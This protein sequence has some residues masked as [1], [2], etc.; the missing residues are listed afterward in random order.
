MARLIY[1]VNDDAGETNA[2]GNAVDLTATTYTFGSLTSNKRA[3]GF[4]FTGVAVPNAATIRR[5]VLK[6]A[7]TAASTSTSSTALIASEAADNAAAF[8]TTGSNI[9]SRSRNTAEPASHLRT[10][11]LPN[12]TYDIDV[13]SSIQAVINRGGWVSGNALAL[14][15]HT[16]GGSTVA[17]Y[18]TLEGATAPQ[19]SIT[20]GDSATSEVGAA[21]TE[22][23]NAAYT[24]IGNIAALDAAYAHGNNTDGLSFTAKNFGFSLSSTHAV[25][26]IQIKIVSS[27]SSESADN[28]WGVELS[29]DGGTSWTTSK[30]TFEIGSSDSTQYISAGPVGFSHTFTY[31][32]MSDANFRVRLTPTQSTSTTDTDTDYVSVQVFYHSTGNPA[33]STLTDTFNA[34]SIDTGK[35]DAVTNTSDATVVQSGG[36]LLMTMS[37]VNGTAFLA[38][39]GLYTIVGSSSVVQLVTYTQSAGSNMYFSLY[40]AAFDAVHF[41]IQNTTLAAKYD[42]AGG[43]QT[44]ASTTY[45]SSTHKWLRMRELSGTFYWDYSTDGVT[46]TNFASVSTTGFTLDLANAYQYINYNSNVGGAYAEFDNFNLPMSLGVKT[47]QGKA[48]IQLTTTKTQTGTARLTLSTQRPQTG[49]AN[50]RYLAEKMID[51]FDDNSLDPIYA[52]VGSGGVA[53]TNQELQITTLLGGQYRGVYTTSFFNFTGSSAYIQVVD[54]GNQALTS[55]ELYPIIAQIDT[56]NYVTWYLS[57]GTLRVYKKLSGTST[58]VGT[59]LTYNAAVHK[60]FRIRESAG[61]IYFDWGTT[62]SGWTNYT[63]LTNP[64]AVTGLAIAI[65]AGTWQ[66]EGSTTVVKYDNLNVASTVQLQTGKARLSKTGTQTQTG[67]SKV[68]FTPARTITGKGRLIF[69]TTRNQVGI[70]SVLNAVVVIQNGVA[71]IRDT[72]SRPQTGKG[73]IRKIMSAAQTGIASVIKSFSQTQT[74]KTNVVNQLQRNQT[75]KGNIAPKPIFPGKKFEYKVSKPDETYVSTLQGVVSDFDYVQAINDSGSQFEMILAKPPDNFGEGE[76]IVFNYDVQVYVY[77][78]DVPTGLKIFDGYISNYT[79][80]FTPDGEHVKVTVLGYGSTMDEYPLMDGTATEVPYL[81]QDPGTILKDIL[82]K[83]AAAGGKITYTVDSI[84]LCGTSVSYTFNTNTVWDGVRK[85]LE[86]A[87]EGW[88]F[89]IDQATNVLHFHPKIEAPDYLFLLDKHIEELEVKKTVENMVNTILFTGKKDAI[90]G[91]P[92]FRFYERGSSVTLYGRKVLRMQDERVI[93]TS[94]ADTMANSVLDNRSTPELQTHIEIIDNAIDRTKGY[95]IETVILGKMLAVGGPGLSGT[96]TSLWDKMEWDV[97]YWDYDFTTL[98]TLVLQITKLKYNGDRVI[99][100][101]STVPPDVN[102]RIEDINRALEASQT[103]DNPDTPD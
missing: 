51:N 74:G 64:F 57:Q 88:Y 40:D 11:D 94:T 75:G 41:Q 9:T 1:T 66:A 101:L 96:G 22:N 50:I 38:S 5:A 21:T 2:A 55:L 53:E 67:T 76:V 68:V 15:I 20:Y 61:T 58:Q 27:V 8:A 102:K 91:I 7:I 82:D 28:R 89:Y 23:V 30:S 84:D 29:W 95:D 6:V 70:S 18:S 48:R 12:G 60:Y 98:S 39:T 37:N 3:I 45:N 56:N 79:P 26:D 87:P 35:W 65:Q 4:R 92:M 80:V 36:K 14:I 99:L 78:Q 19:L 33:T 52:I 71:A 77:D 81:S 43:T 59:G 25:D 13:T 100:D 44:A 49:K 72:T 34:G 63:S 85:C 46:W 24:N 90:T 93:S 16:P 86:L 69:L 32:E 83:F 17:T 10:D 73:R 62:A 47:S 103:A 97:D 54:A 31:S 42:N